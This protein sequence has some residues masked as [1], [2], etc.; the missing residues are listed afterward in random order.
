M[1]S[2]HEKHRPVIGGIIIGV[3]F[4]RAGNMLLQIDKG[5]L[6]GLATRNSDGKKVLVT[7]PHIVSVSG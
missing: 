6:T 1:P 3:A 2:Q 4:T 7:R 5:T